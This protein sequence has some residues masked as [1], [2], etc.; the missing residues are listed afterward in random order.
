MNFLFYF[1]F[2]LSKIYFSV[3]MKSVQACPRLMGL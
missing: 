2:I 1:I 3:Y